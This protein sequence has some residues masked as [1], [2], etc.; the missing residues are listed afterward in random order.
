[1]RHADI[2]E[3]GNICSQSD[4]LLV[5]GSSLSVASAMRFIR[6][7]SKDGKPIVIINRGP[8]RGDKYAADHV[9][10]GTSRALPYLDCSLTELD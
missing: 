4:A 1:M 2:D 10:V 7:A 9:Y 8:T 5:A 6:R 3:A